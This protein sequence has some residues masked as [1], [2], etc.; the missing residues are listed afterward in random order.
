M[1]KLKNLDLYLESKEINNEED[2]DQALLFNKIEEI[3]KETELPILAEV[4]QIKNGFRNIEI[5]DCITFTNTEY[6]NKYFKFA[7]AY[8]ADKS[9][10]MVFTFGES[11]N[12]KKL[13]KRGR[14]KSQIKEGLSNATNSYNSTWAKAEGR[15]DVMASAIGGI[16]SIGGSKKKQEIENEYY[17]KVEILLESVR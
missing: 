2:K 3:I 5:F 8:N 17:D 6:G 10:T 16:M 1:L 12:Q 11:K 15:N 13:D 14:A 4:D 9:A 7:L